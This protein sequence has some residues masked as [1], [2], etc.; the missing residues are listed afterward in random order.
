MQTT[1]SSAATTAGPALPMNT[2]PRLQ[3]RALAFA[4]WAIRT[5][6]RF[7]PAIDLVIRVFIAMVFFKSG[8]TK[9]AS[10]DN[11]IALFE[12]EYMVPFLPPALAA[13]MATAAELGFPVLLVLGLGS[14]FAAAGLFVLNIVAVISYPDVGEVGLK[15][16][17]MWGMFLLVT[18]LHGPG[19]L[20]I[21]HFIRRRFGGTGRAAG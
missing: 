20:S 2:S 8:L 10:W 18:L 9:I 7:A 5:A 13:A 21:D 4:R 17:Q 14:R 1:P 11:T 15:D 16:H 3:D 12:N 19:K 6:E